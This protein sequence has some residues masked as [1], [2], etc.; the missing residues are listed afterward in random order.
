[1]SERYLL[2][3]EKPAVKALDTLPQK[4][5]KQVFLKL[6]ALQGN[7]KP[8]DCKKPKGYPNGYRVDQGEY[9]ILY[10]LEEREV[11]VFRIGK[12]NDDEYRN[13]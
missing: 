3:V 2:R 8:Q 1:M 9:R 11:R 4:A 7:P 13:L 10:T 5:F 6:F 12:R